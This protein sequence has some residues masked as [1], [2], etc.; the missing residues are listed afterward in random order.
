MASEDTRV[1]CGGKAAPASRACVD[2][3]DAHHSGAN[4]VMPRAAVNLA[5]SHPRS[6]QPGKQ[7]CP[8]LFTTKYSKDTKGKKGQEFWSQVTALARRAMSGDALIASHFIFVSFEYFVVH[9]E[10]RFRPAHLI[11]TF[12]GHVMN[13]PSQTSQ[14]RIPRIT[15][16]CTS[17]S[18]RWMPLW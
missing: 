14:A 7:N 13:D 8:G 5:W 16:P 17:V 4:H 2:G 15:W 3:D 12:V 18:R 9:H 1:P 11:R 10:W 6:S